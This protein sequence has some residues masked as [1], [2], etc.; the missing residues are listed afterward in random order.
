M[1]AR[2]TITAACFL[3]LAC[4]TNQPVSD[5]SFFLRGQVIDSVSGAPLADAV[6]GYRNPTVPDSLIFVHDS[7]DVAA[8]NSLLVAKTTDQ[9][10]SFE[11]VFFLSAR[12]TAVYSLLFVYKP[13]FT[14]WRYDRSPVSITASAE[15][16]DEI[17]IRLTAK[18]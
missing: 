9:Q 13:G 7:V 8:P 10:G 15:Y 18:N 2:L 17:V 6:V 14:L 5:Q 4:D 1:T 12:D 3:S 16:V 11:F